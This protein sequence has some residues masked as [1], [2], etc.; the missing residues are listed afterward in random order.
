MK[1]R[2]VLVLKG[3]HHMSQWASMLVTQENLGNSLQEVAEAG[4]AQSCLNASSA[5]ECEGEA[6]AGAGLS[7]LDEH[8][9]F[10]E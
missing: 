2:K 9:F 4:T 10:S 5:G 8:E 3:E 1:N 6:L 7:G